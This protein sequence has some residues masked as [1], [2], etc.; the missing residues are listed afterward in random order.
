MQLVRC[1]KESDELQ[2]V[3]E[4]NP[5]LL[6]GDQINPDDPRRWL[7][8]ER[9]MPVPDPS[10]GTDRWSID[11]LFSDQSAIPTFVECKRFN[12]TRSRREVIGQMMDYAAN[13]HYYWSSTDLSS[14]AEALA[15]RHG[16]S[17]ASQFEILRPDDEL[18]IDM[19]FERVENN[20]REGQVRLVFYLEEA[21]SELKSVVD[22]LNK[23]MERSEVLLVE[24]KQYQDGDVT[25]IVPSLFGYTEEA[26]QVKR[27]VTVTSGTRRRWDYESFF[28]DAARKLD[29]A[30]VERVRKLYDACE[31]MSCGIDWGT[32][33][34]NGSFKVS[35][36]SLGSRTFL[37]IN[38]HGRLDIYFA[39]LSGTAELEQARSSLETAVQNK[40]GMTVPDNIQYP[41]YDSDVWLSNVDVLIDIVRKLVGQ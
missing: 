24:A 34:T 3:L 33:K 17:L 13:G 32:G 12:D 7:Q 39:H 9:E 11:F 21:P 2:S 10:T 16:T 31:S 20:L 27:T 8:I 37:V 18:D 40:L 30:D 28:E 41:G 15:G 29:A 35:H 23:Q 6:P 1:S 4:K 25:V 19:Y 38:S 5:D 22:F 14:R 36:S 26:R